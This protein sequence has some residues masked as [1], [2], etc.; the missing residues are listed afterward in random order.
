MW[1]PSLMLE[2]M[3]VIAMSSVAG[4]L[5][6]AV[7][8]WRVSRGSSRPGPAIDTSSPNPVIAKKLITMYVYTTAGAKMHEKK[9]CGGSQ[10]SPSR[11]L[12]Q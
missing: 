9:G 6:C 12:K 10:A 2:A 1:D 8:W 7:Y 4:S 3:L 11:T 5:A